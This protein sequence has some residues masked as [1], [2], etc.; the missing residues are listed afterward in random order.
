LGS[1]APRI[2]K[3]EGL[4]DWELR[5]TGRRGKVWRVCRL[6]CEVA[7]GWL[8]YAAAEVARFLGGTT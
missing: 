8:G 2:G 6:F 3:R 7:V 4:G 5:S 1:L